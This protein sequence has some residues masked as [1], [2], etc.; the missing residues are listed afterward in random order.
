MPKHR[1]ASISEA[2]RTGLLQWLCDVAAERGQAPT[3]AAI[4]ERFGFAS[5]AS[6]A[7]LM[8]VLE[9]A[10]AIVVRRAHMSRQVVIVAT[11]QAT[12]ANPPPPVKSRSRSSPRPPSATTRP[13]HPMAVFTAGAGATPSAVARTPPER[14]G[15]SGVACSSLSTWPAPVPTA[16]AP[17]PGGKERGCRWPLWGDGRPTHLYCGDARRDVACPYCPTHAARAFA[18]RVPSGAL[19]AGEVGQPQFTP[20][21]GASSLTAGSGFHA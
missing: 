11:G 18:G 12:A 10:G 8:Q 14:A 20:R 2:A 5:I 19:A 4:A 16:P 17:L 1:R 15:G 7:R 13:R 21:H 9:E 3:N 6:A